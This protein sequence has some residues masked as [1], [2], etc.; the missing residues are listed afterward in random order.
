MEGTPVSTSESALTE[1]FRRLFSS[2]LSFTRIKDEA[3]N[4]RLLSKA[5][6]NSN[7]APSISGRSI[8]WKLFLAKHEPLQSSSTPRAASLLDGLRKSRQRYTRLLEEKTKPPDKRLAEP[9]TVGK[10]VTDS[11]RNVNLNNP[12]S[13][14]NENP[15]SEWF[16]GLEVKQ[17]ISQDVERTFPDM[18]FFREAEIQNQLTNILFVYSATHSRI[19]YRQGMHELLAPLYYAVNFDAVGEHA[20]VEH[21]LREICSRDWVAADAWALF[22]AVMDGV[23]SWYEWREPD[24]RLVLQ[25]QQGPLSGHVNLVIPDG[26]HGIQAWVA[27]IVKTCNYIQN[28]LLKKV[29]PNLWA[30]LQKAGIEPQLYGIRWLRLLF[31]REFDMTDTMKLW[32]GLFACDPSL[33]LA[34][35]VCVA[36]LLR[37]RTELINGDYSSQLTSLLRYPSPK[38]S[39]LNDAPTHTCLLLQH[40]LTLQM[41]PNPSTAATINMENRAL[42]DIDSNVQEPPA[43]PRRRPQVSRQAQSSF[44]PVRDRDTNHPGHSRQASSPPLGI[45]EMLARGLLE[46]GE[47]LG[48]NKTLL[49]AVSELKRNIPDISAFVKTP[50]QGSSSFPLEDEHTIPERPPWEPKSR[51]EVEREMEA[52]RRRDKRLGEALGWIVDTL[53]QD[54]ESVKDVQA[55]RRRRGEAV[56]SLAY[57]RDVLIS[58]PAELEEDRL[59]KGNS[60][61]QPPEK[62]GTS[63]A[64]E[65]E[66]SLQQRDRP[67]VIEPPTIAPIA[68]PLPVSVVD[69]GSG[70]K[71]SRPPPAT[72]FSPNVSVARRPASGGADMSQELAK[73]APW[74]RTKSDFNRPT[75]TVL[76]RK[77]PPTSSGRQDSKSV[78]KSREFDPLGAVEYK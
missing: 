54:E 77:P 12:L 7:E 24:P 63:Q 68:P 74:N 10:T 21:E 16:A 69:S 26:R 56:E 2:G 39:K 22:D 75:T 25:E 71:I 62:V 49:S 18:P 57:I 64:E 59:L 29:D 70:R 28:D 6:S 41:S 11:T 52:F 20:S 78:D 1:A 14:H 33:A 36:M 51:L 48:I 46:R 34:Q 9:P 55:L 66:S 47:S 65:P 3:L 50:S 23:S 60:G 73:S 8:A 76:P 38:K 43:S 45:P 42:L 44:I 32:D 19:G 40:A 4:D 27:P 58:D 37:V 35:W 67:T 15:W 61:Q 31:T 5:G 53:L 13:L 72:Q 30:A 17:T